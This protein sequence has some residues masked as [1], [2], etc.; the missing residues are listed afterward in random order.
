MSGY[1]DVLHSNTS[2]VVDSR[3]ITDLNKIRHDCKSHVNLNNKACQ[4][5][6]LCNSSYDYDQIINLVLENNRHIKKSYDDTLFPLQAL[7]IFICSFNTICITMIFKEPITLFLTSILF[8][9]IWV[10]IN[11]EVLIQDKPNVYYALVISLGI[12]LFSLF[13]LIKILITL[14]KI[15]EYQRMKDI[16]TSE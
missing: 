15:V 16:L 10:C 14:L 5:C 6:W 4:K 12:F 1:S 9:S 3:K 13:L 11:G 2:I 7:L 8:T